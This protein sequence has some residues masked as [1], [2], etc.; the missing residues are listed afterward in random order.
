MNTPRDK[1]D[2]LLKG[3]CKQIAVLDDSGDAVVGFNQYPQKEKPDPIKPKRE[4]ILKFFTI[5]PAGEYEIVGRTSPRAQPIRIPHVNNAG[6]KVEIAEQPITM[7]EPMEQVLTYKEALRMATEIAELRSE[8]A[9]LKAENT[10]LQV[11][12]DEIASDLEMESEQNLADEN[13]NSVT[14]IVETGLP[15]VIAL[16]D[17]WFALQEQKVNA[18][19][20]RPMYQA[21]PR[22]MPNNQEQDYDPYQSF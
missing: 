5:A 6:E 17:K 18:M 20:Q 2:H 10:K 7:A 19:Q 14:K 11:E 9:R 15:M 4:Q 13:L 21:P 8:I 1:V 16:A 12:L 3:G 22:P